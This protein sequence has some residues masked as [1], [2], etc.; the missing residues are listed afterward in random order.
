VRPTG[1]AV[2]FRGASLRILKKM[3]ILDEVRRFEI[4]ASTNTTVD[5]HNKKIVSTSDSYTSE[6]LNIMRGDIVSVLHE[7][8]RNDVEYVFDDSIRALVDQGDGVEVSFCH[9][10]PRRFDLVVGADGLHSNVRKLVFGEESRF[11]HN[12]G[13]YIGIFIAPNFMNLDKTGLYYE[14]PGKR[15]SVLSIGRN[16]E[17]LVSFLFA[18]SQMQYDRRNVKQQKQIVRDLF[19][20]EE[21][22]VPRLLCL[23]EEALD[24]YFDSLCQIKMNGWS[25]G[26]FVLLGDAAS[27]PSLLSGMGTNIAIVGA[28]ILARELKKTNGNYLTAFS[29]Y[30]ALM[31]GFVTKHQSLAEQIASAID[32]KGAVIST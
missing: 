31:R 19:A 13:Y 5:K 20:K 11:A 28:H 23:M 9:S 8:T 18:S 21:W 29:R 27:C 1:Y 25:T 3:G 4:P 30:E 7:A 24:F 6:K 16:A 26:R 17:S 15:V 10:Q 22:E 14:T 12:L 32:L 2:D